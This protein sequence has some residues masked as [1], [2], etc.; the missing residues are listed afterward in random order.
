M[1]ASDMTLKYKWTD[2]NPL[3]RPLRQNMTVRIQPGSP[4]SRGLRSSQGLGIDFFVIIFVTKPLE[5]ASFR[6]I[7]ESLLI[8]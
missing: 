3:R 4:T 1:R 5:V 6:R 7:H 8:Y 2:P